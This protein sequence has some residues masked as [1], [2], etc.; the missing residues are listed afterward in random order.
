MKSRLKLF[1]RAIRMVFSASPFQTGLVIFLSLLASVLPLALIW[2][3]KKLIDVVTVAAETGS[4]DSSRMAIYMAIAIAVIYFLEESVQSLVNIVRKKQSYKVESYMFGLI[5]SK[6]VSL[7]LLHFENPEYYDTLSRASREAP[8]RPSSIVSNITVLLRT[9]LSLL[10]MAGL[11]SF[12]NAWLLALLVVANIPGIWLRVHFADILYDFKKEQ[13]PTARK[14]AYFNWLLTGDRPSRELRLFGL[15][16]HFSNIFKKHFDQQQQQEIKII[17]KRSLIELVSGLFKSL[18]VLAAIWYIVNQTIGSWISL[19]ELAMYLLAFKMGM[20]FLRQM[21]GSMAGLYED[22]LFVSDVFDFLNLEEKIIAVSPIAEALP[23]SKSLV[24]SGLSFTYPGSKSSVINGL[25]LEIKKG[26]TLALVGSNGAGKTTLAR[27]ICRL[28]DPIAGK[29]E[30]DGND[31]RNIDPGDYRKMFSVL[32]QDFMLYNMSAGENIV[33]GDIQNSEDRES[34]DSSASLA[35]IKSFIENLPRG[36]DTVIGR[37]FDDSRELSWG[38]WQKIALA[39][40]LYRKSE[41]LIL[42]EPASALDAESEY[43]LF[44]TFKKIADGRTTLLISHRFSNVSIADRIALLED[45][46]IS[47]LGSHEELLK[48]NGRYASMYAMQKSRF[49]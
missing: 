31:I 4:Y 27:L 32:F 44:T 5:H 49:L 22:N 3:I 2:S 13:S 19:G 6:S 34:L 33:A 10:L 23:L 14:A 42:D 41:I 48:L 36:Y 39:R 38:E 47:E 37:L 46:K 18:A 30:I 21:L 25:D 17:R 1:R 26:E 28:Y 7:D 9:G 8:Y 29:V 45:G 35:G 15:G 12:L 20:T 16:E 40:S 11:L 24:L 43:E